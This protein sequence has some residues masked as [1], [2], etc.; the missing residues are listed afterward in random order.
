MDK[1]FVQGNQSRQFLKKLDVLEGLM[2]TTSDDILQKGL[3]YI[4]VLREFNL[5]VDSCFGNRLAP[6][7]EVHIRNFKEAYLKVGISITPK[8]MNNMILKI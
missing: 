8:V 1:I 4:T 6:G 3:P 2:R 5:V 7:Y